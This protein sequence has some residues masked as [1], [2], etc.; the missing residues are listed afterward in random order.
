MLEENL[1]DLS[2]HFGCSPLSQFYYNFVNFR[3]LVVCAHLL[4]HFHLTQEQTYPMLSS[5]NCISTSS[6]HLLHY[7]SSFFLSFHTRILY[8]LTLP[9]FLFH[10]SYVLMLSTYINILL[11]MEVRIYRKKTLAIVAIWRLF[12]R[13]DVHILEYRDESTIGPSF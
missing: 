5:F 6:S 1:R 11:Q 9:Y 10:Q 8:H 7:L 13:V 2:E 3:G 12:G 4:H